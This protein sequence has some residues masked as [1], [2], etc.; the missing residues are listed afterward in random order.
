MEK[1]EIIKYPSKKLMS[2]KETHEYFIDTLWKESPSYYTV[3]ENGPL[4]L[5]GALRALEIMGFLGGQKRPSTINLPKMCT[6][7]SCATE[8]ETCEVLLRK[9]VKAMVE[10]RQ[11]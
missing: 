9:W 4:N 5:I 10:F 2:Q 3:Q 11:F 6:I 8:G 7:W 1:D